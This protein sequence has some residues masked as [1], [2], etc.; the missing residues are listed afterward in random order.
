MIKDF[1]KNIRFILSALSPLR[2]RQLFALTILMIISAALELFSLGAVVPFLA[3]LT[4]P[5]IIFE[6]QILKDI[7]GN[8]GYSD[9][10]EILLPVT[11][12]FV[13]AT[14]LSSSVRLF[15]SWALI[16]VSH[17][18]GKEI[19]EKAF[20][21]VLQQSYL[22]IISRNSSEIVS[23]LNVK[24]T[25]VVVQGIIPALLMLSGAVTLISVAI[26]F[27]IFDPIVSF[28]IFMIFSIFY[29]IIIFLTKNKLIFNSNAMASHTSSLVKII[30]E[31]LGDS[32]NLLMSNQFSPTLNKYGLIEKELRRAQGDS[33]FI[34]ES[35]RFII[36]AFGIILISV[37]AYFLS[38]KGTGITLIPFLGAL[39]LAAQ[40]LLPIAQNIFN[41]WAQI[42]QGSESL[43]DVVELLQL[44]ISPDRKDYSL[45][46][47]LLL[48]NKLHLKD[49]NF[50]YPNTDSPILKNINLSIDKG[51]VTGFL[52]ETGS[53]KSTLIDILM[54]LIIPSSGCFSVDNIVIND[55]NRAFWRQSIAHVAQNVFLADENVIC[56]ITGNE[57]EELINHNRL[58][59]AL[60]ISQLKSVIEDWEFGYK[61]IVGERG[62]NLS[63]GQAQR[64]AIAKALYK[65]SE[66]LILDEATSALDIY[67]EKRLV[68]SLRD[69]RQDLTI[70]MIAHRLET[71]E[72]C[73]QIFE[74]SQGKVYKKKN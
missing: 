34:S 2:R 67:T 24:T 22:N 26:A 65:S 1:T 35:P 30:N 28:S 10:S 16:R 66:I 69:K 25:L 31:A 71:L 47:T 37:L 55:S 6:N 38:S 15:L 21:R 43:S 18:A 56:F 70:I 49:I 62:I 54:G 4:Q 48:K 45:E 11:I 61:T 8:I 52:G 58:T 50:T 14:I 9:G 53:G 29:L 41:G 23:S 60:E 3:V 44:E 5:D 42:K 17:T 63:G 7:L 19:S 59:E 33:K 40:R 32:R 46:S 13:S 36:E 57:P 64:L 27:M 74:V 68:D 20:D 51:S 73:D 39:A 72:N 12:L